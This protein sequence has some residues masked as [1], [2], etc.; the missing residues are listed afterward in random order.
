M[1]FQLKRALV[2]GVNS[3]A[4]RNQEIKYVLRISVLTLLQ[5]APRIVQRWSFKVLKYTS[6]WT[7]NHHEGTQLKF[8]VSRQSNEQTYMHICT[9]QS[10]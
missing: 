10:H 4:G 9:T 8:M 5:L 7:F 3:R 6:A 1:F 2:C